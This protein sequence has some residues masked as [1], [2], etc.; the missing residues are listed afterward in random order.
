MD[1][2]SCSST[3]ASVSLIS[4]VF[5][6]HDKSERPAKVYFGHHDGE[7]VLEATVVSTARAEMSAVSAGCLLCSF[8]FNVRLQA[9][10]RMV[11]LT[12]RVGPP[13][14]LPTESGG[15]FTRCSKSSQPPG[16]VQ[17]ALVLWSLSF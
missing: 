13:R 10:G 5:H 9:M 2:V 6:H 15:K 17:T 11:R 1:H 16:T 3:R 7:G 12:F 4:H 14:K 8:V